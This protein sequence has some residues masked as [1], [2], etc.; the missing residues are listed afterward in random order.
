[1]MLKGNVTHIFWREVVNIAVHI[2]NKVQIRQ[3]NSKTPY[4]LWFGH[5]PTMKYFKIFGSKCYI[6]RE[7]GMGKL[8]L[9]MNY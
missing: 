2:V 3:G 8:V 5:T 6:K 1:M 7:Y 4:E 9:S